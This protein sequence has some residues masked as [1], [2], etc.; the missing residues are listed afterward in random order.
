VN[1]DY[2]YHTEE[3]NVPNTLITQGTNF[4]WLPHNGFY[5]GVS[6]IEGIEH[7]GTE[8]R[9]I[10]GT[11]T[12]TG[13]GFD[14]IL[15][16]SNNSQL[17]EDYTIGFGAPVPVELTS[18]TG[19]L[20]AQDVHIKWQT[21]MEENAD[22]FIVEKSMDGENFT[23]IGK[24]SA[25]GT[26]NDIL[27]YM[28]IDPNVEAGV[29][30]YRLVQYDFNGDNETF[31]PV[32]VNTGDKKNAKIITF[33]NPTVDEISVTLPEM[34]NAG[35]LSIVDVTGKEVYISTV[36]SHRGELEVSIDVSALPRG[37]YYVRFG[38]L[39]DGYM[40]EMIQLL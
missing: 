9:L 32:V 15:E 28:M 3:V 21:A 30:Y 27:D 11:K 7:N 12:I 31:G 4:Y 10:N 26:S 24:V 2:Y 17:R 5:F 34:G 39:T 23:E 38:N 19:E 8:W 13:T 16:V 6:N 20:V 37:I 22:Y 40:T 14:G 25:A 35:E 29:I 36:E 1:T 18:F 33:P